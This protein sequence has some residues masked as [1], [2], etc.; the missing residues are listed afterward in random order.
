MS[1]VALFYGGSVMFKKNKN[2]VF[3]A[4]DHLKAA[5]KCMRQV[6]MDKWAART[7]NILL[8]FDRQIVKLKKYSGIAQR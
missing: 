7:E 1:T 5:I 3:E 6:G 8:D 2:P 4:R